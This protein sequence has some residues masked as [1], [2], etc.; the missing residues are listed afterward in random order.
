M[1]A[2]FAA[3]VAL[4]AA[5]NSVALQD[6]TYRLVSQF[7]PDT[8]L[9]REV[10]FDNPVLAAQIDESN[11]TLLVSVHSGAREKSPSIVEPDAQESRLVAYDLRAHRIVWDKSSALIPIAAQRNR[12]IL[13]KDGQHGTIIRVDDGRDLTQIDGTAVTWPDGVALAITDNDLSR[14]DLATG[15]SVW[16]ADREIGGNLDRVIRRDSVAYVVADGIQKIDLRHGP[17]WSYRVQAS[18][19]DLYSDAAG[20]TVQVPGLHGGSRATNLI[21]T[22]LILG[23]DVFFAADTTVMKLDA[24]SGRIRWRQALPHPRTRS[25]AQRVFGT[26]GASEFLGRLVVRDA[27]RHLLVA[28]VGWA[29]GPKYNLV[30]DPPTVALLSKED[31]R[32]VA[33]TQVPGVA[34][35]NDVFSTPL[36]TYVVAS[37]RVLALDDSLAVRATWLAPLNCR[38]LGQFLSAGDAIVLTTG[39]GIAAL[40]PDSLRVDWSIRL[41]RML[42]LDADDEAAPARYCVSTQGIV[43]LDKGAGL[44]PDAYYPLRGSWAELRNGWLV[45][46]AGTR[47]RIV[48]LL[49]RQQDSRTY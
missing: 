35:L 46:G 47:V 21:A 38:P 45:M 27:G 32:V 44:R 36:G 5:R 1:L 6:T 42:A 26:P 12:A 7:G 9:I 49:A 18:R 48:T 37:D 24:D 19:K 11:G 39:P 15:A 17:L 30:A 29:S 3:D 25:L 28:S 40:S 34:F 16:T 22:P 23:D 10:A 31:G 8:L 14:W 43:R 13:C 2:V 33:R 20:Q 41:G 4:A